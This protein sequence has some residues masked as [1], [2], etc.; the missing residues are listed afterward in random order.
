[1]Q[2]KKENIE[3]LVRI[4]EERGLKAGILRNHEKLSLI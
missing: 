2:V 4:L 1:M 3:E